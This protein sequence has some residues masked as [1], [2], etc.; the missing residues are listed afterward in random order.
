MR[1]FFP[2][3]LDAS[4]DFGAIE[5]IEKNPGVEEASEAGV[6]ATEGA[7]GSTI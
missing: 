7:E 5:I 3:L 1:D 4:I 6:A 2:K